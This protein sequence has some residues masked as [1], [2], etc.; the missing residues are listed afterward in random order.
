M[1]ALHLPV[2]ELRQSTGRHLQTAGEISEKIRQT[3]KFEPETETNLKNAIAEF[4]AQF[5]AKKD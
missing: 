5:M 2:Q 4:K 1:V 3:K